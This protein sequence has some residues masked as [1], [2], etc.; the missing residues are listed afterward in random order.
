MAKENWREMS[1][2]SDPPATL[3]KTQIV[4][5]RNTRSL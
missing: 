3:S 2:E 5:V 4:L 1:V